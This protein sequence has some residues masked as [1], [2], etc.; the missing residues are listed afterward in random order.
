[1]EG[2]YW[3]MDIPHSWGSIFVIPY[4]RNDWRIKEN[5][6]LFFE[7]CFLDPSP[8][9]SVSGWQ[10]PSPPAA[11]PEGEGEKVEK[12]GKNCWWTLSHSHLAVTWLWACHCV[13]LDQNISV[14]SHWTQAEWRNLLND[15]CE[16][17]QSLRDTSTSLRFAQYDNWF[18]RANVKKV[19]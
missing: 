12:S 13:L 10:Y 14:I 1:M 15:V 9:S 6:N 7:R 8:E 17:K 4:W 19:C 3:K 5:L 2:G 11:S 18:C 16:S